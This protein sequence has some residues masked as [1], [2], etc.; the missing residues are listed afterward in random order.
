M[1]V[2]SITE[3][4]PWID[5]S[6]DIVGCRVHSTGPGSG[7]L[8]PGRLLVRIK[9]SPC[10]GYSSVGRA[11]DCGSGCRG[12]KSHY[13]PHCIFNHLEATITRAWGMVGNKQ[14]TP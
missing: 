14:K 4:Q 2:A 10:G 1:N 3:N 11:P 12:F 9:K 13:P 8:R 7:R 6:P 5:F